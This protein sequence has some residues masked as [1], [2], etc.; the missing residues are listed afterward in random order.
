MVCDHNTTPPTEIIKFI[1]VANMKYE[2]TVH[3]II[4]PIN[5][6][7]CLYVVDL[8]AQPLPPSFDTDDP[9]PQTTRQLSSVSCRAVH[10]T[11]DE[12]FRAVGPLQWT[13]GVENKR[14]D[15]APT[16]RAGLS[17]APDQISSSRF[18][19]VVGMSGQATTPNAD[20]TTLRPADGSNPKAPLDSE[21]M[22]PTAELTAA[23]AT[24]LSK[25]NVV[26]EATT[27]PTKRSVEKEK[28]RFCKTAN[29]TSP[30]L[31]QKKKSY[32]AKERGA[33]SQR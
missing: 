1:R 13:N 18:M 8:L 30:A 26:P 22:A 17:P 27:K 32:V 24:A 9:P 2:R 21:I 16:S 10:E 14:R 11:T 15:L 12:I 5:D 31:E 20:P 29:N 6:F 33:R 19:I 7:D 4:W 3:R 23:A 28:G 25:A